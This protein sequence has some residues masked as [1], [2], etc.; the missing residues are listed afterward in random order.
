MTKIHAL[1]IGSRIARVKQLGRLPT[2][3]RRVLEL[4]EPLLQHWEAGLAVAEQRANH[5]KF[6]RTNAANVGA[7][8][9]DE[10]RGP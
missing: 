9:D 4:C 5:R 7:A 10:R 6:A 1:S 8:F 2:P 3:W